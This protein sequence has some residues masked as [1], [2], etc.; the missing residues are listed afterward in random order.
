MIQSVH[1][2][3]GSHARQSVGSRGELPCCPRSGERGYDLTVG[4]VICGIPSMAIS[5]IPMNAAAEICG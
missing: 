3:T 2:K 1:E 4:R 5:A